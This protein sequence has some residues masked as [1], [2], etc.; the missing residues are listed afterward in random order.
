[1]AR[2][3]STS[4]A[5]STC[6]PE[7]SIACEKN[8]EPCNHGCLVAAISSGRSEVVCFARRRPPGVGFAVQLRRV[9]CLAKIT[10]VYL[11]R[12]HPSSHIPSSP[13]HLSRMQDG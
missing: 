1:M 13:L 4:V 6:G 5:G 8:V 12:K 9:G 11:R 7:A 10:S 3:S 2:S